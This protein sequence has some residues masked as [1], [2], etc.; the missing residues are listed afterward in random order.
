MLRL[1]VRAIGAGEPSSRLDVM[2]DNRPH[3]LAEAVQAINAAGADIASIMTLSGSDGSKEMVIR[4]R[5]ISPAPAVWALE[6]H[7]FTARQAWGR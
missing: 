4:L 6:A 5:T 2:L 1:F 7:R 3:A